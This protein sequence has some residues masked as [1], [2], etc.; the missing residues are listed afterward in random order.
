MDVKQQRRKTIRIIVTALIILTLAFIWGHSCMPRPKSTEESRFV[1]G[2]LD[3]VIDGFGFGEILRISEAVLRKFA[4]LF[5]YCVLG[6]QL[7]LFFSLSEKE[8]INKKSRIIF[9]AALIPSVLT[10]ILDEII[11]IFSG[12]YS[13]VFDVCLDA[14]G[15]AAGIGI[16]LLIRKLY[17][18]KHSKRES[19]S[20]A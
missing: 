2:I 20:N 1:K 4:H 12:R 13:S 8:T 10:G 6:A 15:A 9:L 18:K 11:Q 7:A 3:S 14:V 5:E 19:A 16:M 17:L